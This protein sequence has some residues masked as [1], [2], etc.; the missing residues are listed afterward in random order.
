MHLL[1]YL[2]QQNVSTPSANNK[3]LQE[4]GKYFPGEK[5]IIFISLNENLHGVNVRL[6]L[7]ICSQL[8]LCRLC[9]SQF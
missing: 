2:L 3:I 7:P 8:M 4:L 1:E 6:K 9:I 5:V